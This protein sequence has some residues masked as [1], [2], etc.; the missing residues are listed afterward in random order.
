MLLAILLGSL[1]QLGPFEAGQQWNEEAGSW[2]L[3]IGETDSSASTGNYHIIFGGT[4]HQR[5]PKEIC[6]V[7]QYNDAEGNKY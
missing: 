1:G 4:H 7:E 2:I 3:V 5:K 6:Q